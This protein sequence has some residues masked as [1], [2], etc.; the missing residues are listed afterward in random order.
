MNPRFLEE[1]GM[2]FGPFEE[3]AFWHVEDSSAYKAIQDS[4]RM[5]EFVWVCVGR[6]GRPA[7][8]VVEA[9]SSSPRPETQPNFEAFIH[10]V[11]EKWV[12][13]FSLSWA[14]CLNRHSNRKEE[15]PATMQSLELAQTDVKFVLVVKDH[16][17]DWLPP[18]KD[19]L[20][21]ALRPTLKTWAFSDPGVV[22]LNEALA[23][24]Y[25]LVR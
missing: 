10:E 14:C 12:N 15:L 22:V 19:A 6:K 1:S 4:V 17:P 23:R 5:A 9:K 11:R 13:A 16:K 7:L 21:R 8:W 24:E 25:G 2:K 3:D 20:Y 18:L